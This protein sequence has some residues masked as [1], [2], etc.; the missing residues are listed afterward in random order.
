L[1]LLMEMSQILEAAV[2]V[3]VCKLAY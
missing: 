3:P 1:L 2:K